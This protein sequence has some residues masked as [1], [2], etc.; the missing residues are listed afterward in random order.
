[1]KQVIQNYKTGEL[2]VENV[3]MPTVKNDSILVKTSFSLISAGTERTKV[4]TAKMNLL[5]KAISRLDLVKILL[6]NIKQEGLVFTL[7]KA[8]NKLDTPITL[9]YSLSGEIVD[10]GT[11]V[12]NFNVGDRIA[13]I[14]E[15]YAS[16]AEY[17]LVPENFARKIP[18]NV[19]SIDASF[20]GL[21][22][23]AL[24]AVEITQVIKKEKV[25]VIGLGLLGQIIVQILKSKGCD[26]LGIELDQ[27]KIDLAVSLGMNYGINPMKDN[28]YAGVNT[29][30]DNQGADAVII[31]AASKNNLPLDIAGK[32]SRNKGRVVLV[33]A[34]PIIIPRNEYYAKELNFVISRGF[35]ADL[36]YKIENDRYYPYN[37][38]PVSM[39]DNMNNFLNLLSENKVK[40]SSLITHKFV[41][42][43]A[44]SAYEFIGGGK[45]KYLGIVFTY[46]EISEEDTQRKIPH[47]K[48][49]IEQIFLGFGMA[50]ANVQDNKRI[51]VGFIGAGSFAQGYILPTLLKNKNV[52]LV[53]IST[54]T[55]ISAHS[56]A[57][58]FKF[59]YGATDY[60]KILDDENIDTVFI[61]TRHNLHAKFVEEA[62]D[63]GKNI[64][65]EKPLCVNTS[66]LE[67]IRKIYKEGR[68][69]LMIGFNRRFAPLI[70]KTKEF[71]SN[72]IGPLMIHYRINAGKLPSNHW[73]LDS[74][75][76][77]GRI[78]GEG[79]HFIDLIN[80]IIGSKSIELYAVSLTNNN[81]ISL[82]DYEVVMKYEDGSVGSIVY[83]SIGDESFSREYIEIF[84]E[85]STVT[86]NNFKNAV[87]SRSGSVSKINLFARD[88]GH[89]NE[90]NKFID[91]LIK[92]KKSII[93][94]NDIISV[95]ETTFKIEELLKKF[96]IKN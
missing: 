81:K 8:F 34:L 6:N 75:E 89:K 18:N 17:N 66:E 94:F 38:K 44:K 19:S 51:N 61:A 82:E 72:R 32:I 77:G 29:F 87:F 31:S 93:D 59:K 91:S 43:D 15:I 88:M 28:I 20:I 37:Y 92:E 54:A 21:G 83:N 96:I 84:G 53:G 1:M 5:E 2:K 80:Y 68:N 78:I 42:D 79:C 46:D 27:S 85:N 90:I 60:Q 49:I 12:K 23:I 63:K 52:N 45:E 48:K 9:G 73:A 22:A 40:V 13:C 67:N 62:L 33:G 41:L 11:N 76:G 16:H 26:V 71:F 57:K 24:N 50:K 70:Y 14:G 86:I 95:T 35:G 56:A 10:K 65:V 58:K 25:V 3:P 64:F 30:T 74:S 4:E 7:K 47:T 69:V 55:S 36:Y 39:Q